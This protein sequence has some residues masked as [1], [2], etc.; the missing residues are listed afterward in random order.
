MI[1]QETLPETLVARCLDVLRI[2]SP[3][4]RDLIRVVVEVVHEL[5]DTSDPDAE[6]N[7]SMAVSPFRSRFPS[8]VCVL[9]LICACVVTERWKHTRW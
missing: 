2:L 7:L 1:G 6:E 4:E 8:F 9:I 5:R 3:N